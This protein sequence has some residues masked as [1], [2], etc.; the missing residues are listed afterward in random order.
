MQYLWPCGLKHTWYPHQAHTDLAWAS[1][2]FDS[3][4]RESE[5]SKLHDPMAPLY[6]ST[7]ERPRWNE[8]HTPGVPQTH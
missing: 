4:Q 1:S 5:D 7:G 8:Q 3:L 6:L 2:D